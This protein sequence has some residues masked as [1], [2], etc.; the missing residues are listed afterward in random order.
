MHFL[1]NVIAQVP[2]SAQAMVAAT[3]RTIFEQPD[4]QAARAQL[5]QVCASLAE[6][7][8]KV[9]ALLEE[10]EGE[11]LTFYDYP[12]EHWRQ[13][14]STNPLARLNKELKRRSAVVGIFP[15][16][17]AVL[18]LVGA[19][20]AEQHD[21][22]QVGRRYFSAESLAKLRKEERPMEPLAALAAG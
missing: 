15:N 3:V 5:R 8:P 21:E 6:R 17:A 9:V 18:R 20:L 10:A 16:R 12:K 22:W 19:V 13:I 11:I 4:R 14:Y 2:K 7:F 1:R